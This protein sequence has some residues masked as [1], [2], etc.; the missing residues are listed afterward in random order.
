MWCH[1]CG[2][3][4]TLTEGKVWRTQ[5]TKLEHF[6]GLK[7]YIHTDNP[8]HNITLE[9]TK[10]LSVEHKWFERGVKEAIYIRAMNPSLNRDGGRYNLPL[11]WNNIIKERVTDGAGTTNGGGGGRLRN[12]VSVPVVSNTIWR[13]RHTDE[14]CSDSRKLCKCCQFFL[15]C[16]MKL[17]TYRM[18][19]KAILN[20]WFWS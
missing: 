2:W 16:A 10:I 6:R 8:N 3:N 11:V 14:G 7:T 18:V 4:G 12:S 19:K 20:Q 15:S 13:L 1:L 9:N 17:Q 5:E